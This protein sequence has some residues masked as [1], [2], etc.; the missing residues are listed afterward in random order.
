MVQYG[1]E[2]YEYM[3]NGR[4]IQKA[5]TLDP[6]DHDPLNSIYKNKEALCWK[7]FLYEFKRSKYLVTHEQ[8]IFPGHRVPGLFTPIRNHTKTQLLN[9]KSSTFTFISPP[10]TPR[11]Y[12]P[13]FRGRG[14][15][16]LPSIHPLLGTG[17]QIL[18]PYR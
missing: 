2:K 11:N 15:G 12:R 9:L 4:N 6:P 18:E 10:K 16:G 13:H 5:R 8:T 1:M 7:G 14:G 17:Q 3:G